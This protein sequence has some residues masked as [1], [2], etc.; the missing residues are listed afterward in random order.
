MNQHTA[1]QKPLLIAC[2][3]TVL[4]ASA[5]HAQNR[6]STKLGELLYESN[7]L[8]CHNTQPNWRDQKQ[9]RDWDSL[10]TQIK[11]WQNNLGL[12]WDDAQITQVALYMNRRYYKFSAPAPAGQ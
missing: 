4:S 11:R 8:T 1:I 10:T 3:L 6:P 7:C 12:R 5:T 2:A 9:A